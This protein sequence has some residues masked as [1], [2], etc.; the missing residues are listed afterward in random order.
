MHSWHSFLSVSYTH[1]EPGHRPGGHH[2]A[3]ADPAGVAGTRAAG[4]NVSISTH[5]FQMIGGIDL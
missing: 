3:G 1:L 5:S 2:E 4:K